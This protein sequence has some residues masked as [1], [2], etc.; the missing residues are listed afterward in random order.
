MR[1]R[2]GV[3]SAN[4]IHSIFRNL[5]PIFS[6]LKPF[7]GDLRAIWSHLGPSEANLK[8]SWGH[9]GPILGPSWAYLGLS[10]RHKNLDFPMVFL[11]FYDIC[12]S[13]TILSRYCFIFRDLKPIFSDLKPFFGDL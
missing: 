7:L 13:S 1:V 11:T 9:L 4:A 2:V 5:K 6:D 3:L 8:P 10:S 12:A